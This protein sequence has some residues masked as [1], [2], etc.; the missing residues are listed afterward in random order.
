MYKTFGHA[1]TFLRYHII[2]STKYRRKFLNEHRQTIYDAF[3]YVERNSNFLILFKEI[4]KDHIH[5]CVEIKP[6]LSISSV[7]KR[8]KQMSQIYMYKHINLN[9]I[10]R[11]KHFL[12]TRGYFVSTIGNCSVDTLQK[13]IENQG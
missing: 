6:N 4:D 13:Y 1:K 3:D 8:L 5:L 9:T 12:W 2:F 11:K 10:Y 7:V